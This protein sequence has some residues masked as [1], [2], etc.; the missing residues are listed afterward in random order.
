MVTQIGLGTTSY[1]RYGYES[2]FGTAPADAALIQY[3]G[4]NIKFTPS[5]KN[6]V[7]RIADLNNRNY[8]KIVAKKF[9]GSFTVDGEVA[10]LYW[11]KAVLGSVADTGAGPYAHTYDEANTPPSITIQSSEDLDTNSE[12]TFKGCS[13]D[14][15][16]FTLNVGEI[17]TFRLDGMYKIETKDSTL[18]TNGNSFDP[19]EVFTV[20]Q[21]F[22]ELPNGTTLAEVESAEITITNNVEYI[23]D[24]NSRF[25]TARAF[26]Q[27]VYEVRIKKVR[28]QDLDFLD[29]MY[30][31]TATP[32]TPTT[33]ATFVMNLNNGL[34]STS[35]RSFVLGLANLM[36][37]THTLPYT[38]GEVLKEDV[39]L[40]ALSLD[41]T[42]KAVYTNN[43]A[44]AP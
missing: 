38:P 32:G 33:S 34:S 8:T 42:L 18:N 5:I 1:A 44:T 4:H 26:K 36:P 35:E 37:D 28:E 19:E 30:G 9:E 25:A 39:T 24:L 41:P 6:N 13:I 29:K 22:I 10:S 14:K 43:T 3:F 23:W 20:G 17:A 11:M 2:A 27:R 40:L 15:C 31:D 7:E 21:M 16:T 12:R